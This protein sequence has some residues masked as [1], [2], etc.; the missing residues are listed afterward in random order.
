M[1]KGKFIKY[2]YIAFVVVIIFSSIGCSLEKLA[3]RS[4]GAVVNYGVEAIYE[5]EDLLIAEQAI[6]SNLKLIEGLIKG[7]PGNK[8][9]L[10]LA[11]EGYTGYA[12]GFVEDE[13]QER[14][15]IFYDRAKNYGLRILKKN[16]TFTKSLN[17]NMDDFTKS[18]NTFSKSDV[19]ALFWTC[20][21]W[22]GWVNI[23]RH[24]PKALADMGKVEVLMKRVLELDEEYHY[25]GAHLFLAAF[26]GN[27]SKMFGG[28]PEK[29]K[30]H[31]D[32]FMEISGGKFLMGQVLFAKYYAVQMQ[33]PVLYRELLEEVAD[34]PGN[35][36]PEQRLVN[37]IAK[38]KAADLLKKLDNYF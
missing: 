37:E 25:G 15:R 8:S 34:T 14:A 18:L 12:L 7:D 32:R 11:S 24:L 31:F 1:K 22:G 28:D 23:S 10:L 17:S 36:I 3:I 27:R 30:K 38:V 20:N 2:K 35:S 26:Y 5:E 33:D 19:P 21:A 6:M 9:L 16:S 29:S 13:S 4:T